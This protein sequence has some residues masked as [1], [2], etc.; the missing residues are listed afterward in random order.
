M[1][2]DLFDDWLSA[3]NRY[4]GSILAASMTDDAVYVD[5]PWG[6]VL[7]PATVVEHVAL[8][9]RNSSDL[10]VVALSTQRDG[11][12][13]AFEWK[14]TGTNDGPIARGLPPSGKTWTIR[15]A[16]IGVTEGGKIREHRDYWDLC[17][18]LAQLGVSPPPQVDWVLAD[19]SEET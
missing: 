3:W 12:R 7:T 8:G 13:Y 2:T 4:D 1:A 9:H 17:G 11:D 10:S 16:S 15:G 19:W 18:W 6:R 5:V 14:M